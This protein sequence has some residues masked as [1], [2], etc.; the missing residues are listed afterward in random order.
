[1]LK[2]SSH[3]FNSRYVGPTV[4]FEIQK[5]YYSSNTFS[6]CSVEQ[7]LEFFLMLDTRCWMKRWKH[8]LP[9]RL[10]KIRAL[11]PP[12]QTLQHVRNL[13]L[14]IKAE[15]F[16]TNKPDKMTDIEDFA[17]E[18]HFLRYTQ[19]NLTRLRFLSTHLSDKSNS[20]I[21]FIVMTELAQLGQREGHN[22]FF[23]NILQTIRNT[24]YML[25][26]DV[27]SCTVKIIHHDD[28]VSSFPRDITKIFGLT[29]EQWQLV[30]AGANDI[31][32]FL[33]RT[34]VQWSLDR[35]PNRL[36]FYQEKSLGGG[37]EETVAEFYLAP[38]TIPDERLGY[39]SI[40]G[41]ELGELLHE[42]W[43]IASVLD[44]ECKYPVTQGRYWCADDE[45]VDGWDE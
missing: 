15:H 38:S 14:R 11:Q 20:N 1:M 13:Q 45:M 24:V 18:Q 23:I 43:G 9:P 32:S 21:E 28:A 33:Q 19:S 25:V 8:S 3:I 36:T 27:P 30:S 17:Y 10:S 34:V 31:M 5:V 40:S 2:L 22:R 37:S 44:T 4:S 41:Q 26:H 39:D 12:F 29:K 42:R 7:G 35:F 16:E 6:I